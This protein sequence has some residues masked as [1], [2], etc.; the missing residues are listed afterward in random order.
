MQAELA[1]LEGARAKAAA[2]LASAQLGAGDS[3]HRMQVRLLAAPQ[4]CVRRM[5]TTAWRRPV[6][7]IVCD[8][9]TATAVAVT[10]EA[11]CVC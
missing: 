11:C 1:E 10:C 8:S 4:R 7:G 5:R 6:C 9:R 3:V 2:S